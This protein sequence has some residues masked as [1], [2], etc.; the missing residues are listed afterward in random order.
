MSLSHAAESG[1]SADSTVQ[2]IFNQGAATRGVLALV[3]GGVAIYCLHTGQ[4]DR[5][6]GRLVWAAALALGSLLL[7]L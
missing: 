2:W 7:F 1:G 6:I 3:L 5:D 4:R